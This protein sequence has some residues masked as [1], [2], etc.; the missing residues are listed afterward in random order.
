[1]QAIEMQFN[2]NRLF[3][4]MNHVLF[5]HIYIHIIFEDIGL[6]DYFGTSQ[7]APLPILLRRVEN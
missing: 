2:R 6:Q 4:N 1:M 7:I 5:L 3:A